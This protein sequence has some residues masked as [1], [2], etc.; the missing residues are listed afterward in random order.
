[1]AANVI[2][3]LDV[4]SCHFVALEW[5]SHYTFISIHY[6]LSAQGHCLS[7]RF[8]WSQFVAVLGQLL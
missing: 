3:D 7:L 1:M 5:P 8:N 6:L 2:I 4:G